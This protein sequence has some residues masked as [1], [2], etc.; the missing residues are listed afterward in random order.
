MRYTLRFIGMINK[1]KAIFYGYMKASNEWVSEEERVA[2]DSAHET[3]KLCM[4]VCIWVCCRVC[5]CVCL[6]KIIVVIAISACERACKSRHT[7]ESVYKQF[8][9]YNNKYSAMVFINFNSSHAKMD[10][11]STIFVTQILYT[12]YVYVYMVEYM[13]TRHRKNKKTQ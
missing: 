6:S 4:R 8:L 11:F 10:S 9:L 3:K 1:T 5:V 13:W 12:L 2:S 7:R